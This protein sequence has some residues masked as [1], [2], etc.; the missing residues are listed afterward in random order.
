MSSHAAGLPYTPS[1]RVCLLVGEARSS[2][3]GTAL[4]AWG[5]VCE[6]Q[7]AGVCPHLCLDAHGDGISDR[8][9]PGIPADA[10]RAAGM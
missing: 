7:D 6:D 1:L 8:V 5:D 9:R 3:G 4:Q 10:T 2:I